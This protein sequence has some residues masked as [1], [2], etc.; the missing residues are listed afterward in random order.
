[1]LPNLVS[2]LSAAASEFIPSFA[3]HEPA[4]VGNCLQSEQSSYS[5]LYPAKIIAGSN[6]NGHFLDIYIFFE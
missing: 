6:S 4:K 3:Y 2:K 1:M 5:E